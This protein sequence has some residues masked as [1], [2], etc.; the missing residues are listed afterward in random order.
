MKNILKVVL[1]IIGT[2]IGAG[3]A[4]GKE[5]YVFF[6]KYGSCGLYGMILSGIIL[7]LVIYKVLK[8][9]KN[10]KID[11][12]KE[13]ITRISEHKKINKILSN[14]INIFL[15]MS[16]FVMVSGFASYFYEQLNINSLIMAIIMAVLCLVTFNRSIDGITK[17]NTILIPFLI[18]FIIVAAIINGKYFIDNYNYIDSIFINT[19]SEFK[20]INNWIISAIL[21]ASYNSIILIPILIGV[22]DI[23]ER[24][25]NRIN[26]DKKN[27]IMDDNFCFS[28][29]GVTCVCIRE[30]GESVLLFPCRGCTRGITPCLVCLSL[31][32]MPALPAASAVYGGQD[33]RFRR[34]VEMRPLRASFF[35]VST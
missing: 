26:C 25:E 5:V 6:N 13:L 11:N 22:Q 30:P 17:A 7:S 28:W 9:T 20:I 19:N 15:L 10:N 8:L 4:S 24:R 14:I 31:C 32:P 34:G 27:S 16:F 21:Y 33:A 18:I 3:F 29:R 1:V 23:V 35:R 2:L 12:Y